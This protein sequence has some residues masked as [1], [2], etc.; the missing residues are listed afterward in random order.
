VPGEQAR[1]EDRGSHVATPIANRIFSVTGAR[2]N[3][4]HLALCIINEPVL[5]IGYEEYYLLVVR[6]VFEDR[7][8]R[9]TPRRFLHC[10]S[11][12]TIIFQ[13]SPCQIQAT[14][15][16]TNKVHLLYEAG[17]VILCAAN[18]TEEKYPVSMLDLRFSQW[19]LWRMWFSGL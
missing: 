2:H 9:T 1:S 14:V 8:S 13:A 15:N 19:G 10:Q 18:L 11:S 16:K 7:G 5:E 4:R 6:A 12:V 3:S 17:Y